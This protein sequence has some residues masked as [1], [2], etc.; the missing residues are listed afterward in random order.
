[1]KK[2]LALCILTIIVFGALTISTAK[3]E[4]PFDGND[5]YGFPLTFFI[6]FSGMCSPCPPNPTETFYLKLLG[7]VAVAFLIA[8][9]IWTVYTKL[10]NTLQEKKSGI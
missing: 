3:I 6:R 8:I 2:Y 5:T 4:T 7:D 10:R 9:I 1:M